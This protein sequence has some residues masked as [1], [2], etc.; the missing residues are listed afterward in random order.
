MNFFVDEYD[1]YTW[2]KKQN[3]AD[4]AVFS[5]IN[6]LKEIKSSFYDSDIV[7]SVNKIYNEDLDYANNFL[8]RLLVGS[9][10]AKEKVKNEERRSAKMKENGKMKKVAQNQR[11]NLYSNMP[12]RVCPKLPAVR[13]DRLISTYNCRFYC[14]D[15]ITFDDDPD[16]V[17]CAET[18]WRRHIMDKFSREWKNEE[19]KWVGGYLN[20]RFYKF[21]DNGTPA[22]PDVPSDHGNQMQL[23]HGVRTRQARPD[24]FSYERRLEQ[25]R[26][27][28]LHS[29]LASRKKVIRLASIQD[30]KNSDDKIFSAFNHI[31]E[32]KEKGLDAE[33]I[34][35]ATSKAHKMSI[36]NT[37]KLFHFASKLKDRHQGFAYA[38]DSQSIKKYAESKTKRF[39][40]VAQATPSGIRL[41]DNS[42]NKVGVTVFVANPNGAVGKTL[43]DNSTIRIETGTA[44]VKTS[45]ENVY[46]IV[47]INGP[48]NGQFI[49]FE[50]PNS[51]YV[52]TQE[53]LQEAADQTGLNE[54]LETL[55]R[56]YGEDFSSNIAQ[57]NQLQANI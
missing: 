22:N 47:D 6:A 56:T 36:D 35:S 3:S 4:A 48:H 57:V 14:L 9:G 45:D 54:N 51:V 39:T 43:R 34:I 13:G 12:L 38:C 25:R 8:Y 37:G 27:N 55:E 41:T 29:I 10:L 5:L 23:P 42:I 18:L 26:G 33:K 11:T 49:V 50:N 19:G 17:Y 52:N 28:E 53:Q 32:L 40:K 2:I 7:E 1:L 46:Q 20:E 44:L 24:E 31:L 15:S 16:R 21:P 30:Q